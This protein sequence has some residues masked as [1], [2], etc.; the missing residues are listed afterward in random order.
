MICPMMQN[1]NIAAPCKMDGGTKGT[2][3]EWWDGLRKQCVVKSVAGG[4]EGIERILAAVFEFDQLRQIL[5]LAQ[6]PTNLKRLKDFFIE[7]QQKEKG[8]TDGKG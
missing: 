7:T 3:C 4:L 6:D 5:E 8:K 1:N 2:G